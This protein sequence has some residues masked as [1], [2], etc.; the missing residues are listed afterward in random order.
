MRGL[1]LLILRL[2]VGVGFVA[3]GVPKLFSSWGPS[4]RETTALLENAGV[5]SAY[6]VT[7]AMGVVE[8]L[9]GTLLL[10]GGYT[11]W[12]ALLLTVTTAAVG[13]VLYF[14]NGYFLNWSLD[15]S[16]QH[17]YELHVLRVGALACLMLAGPGGLS[18]D[19]LREKQN[20]L[21][22]KTK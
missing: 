14:P 6:L 19:A 3:H 7:M 13:G 2:V 12:A 18:F 9:G 5:A 10:V 8:T 20:G 16:T 22:R 1:G 21:K 15:G 17:G 4:P 11:V